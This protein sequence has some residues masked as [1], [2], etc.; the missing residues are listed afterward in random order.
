[1]RSSD[2]RRWAVKDED[3]ELVRIFYTRHEAQKFVL[4]NWSIEYI[5]PRPK[6]TIQ[7]DMFEEAPF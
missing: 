1:M 2:R 3:G 6:P 7:L 4:R 5:K